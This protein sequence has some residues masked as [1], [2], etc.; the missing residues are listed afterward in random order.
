MNRPDRVTGRVCLERGSPV[1]VLTRWGPGGGLRNVLIQRKDGDLVV[2][3]FRGLRS[4]RAPR[5]GSMCTG[6]GGLDLAVASVLGGTLAWVADNDPAAARIL[7]HRFP[8]V[9]NHG[10]ITAVDW[11]TTEPVDVLTAGFPCQPVSAAGRRKGIS[12]ERWLW[13]D[14]VAAIGRM[15]SRPGLLVFENVPGLLSAN[16]GNAMARVVQGLA[17]LGY[18]GRYRLVRASSV[19]APHRR[20]RWFC[21]ACPAGDTF[22]GELQRRGIPAILRGQDTS[23]PAA[24]NE[25][26]HLLPTPAARDWKSGQ[27]NIMDRNSRPLNEVIETALPPTPRATDGTKGGP[28]QRG[29]SGDL[30]LPS[31]VMTLMAPGSA[32]HPG[33]K[34]GIY[35][36]AIRRWEHI[37]ARPAPH[38]TE[39]GR[40]GERLSPAFTE[41]MM[42]LP[43]GWVTGVPGLS[44]NAQLKAL[45]NGVV[46]QQAAMALRLLLG[47]DDQRNI[48]TVMRV[49]GCPQPG[50]STP[51][52]IPRQ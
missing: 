35:E 10:D 21:I 28:G 26:E 9:P 52:D 50:A 6:Y 18:V 51:V 49:P 27:S 29:S 5:I 42:G 36:A 11:G 8:H 12:D 37:F 23:L 14:I 30:M 4:V 47:E 16:S 17:K 34:W 40:N 41:W 1:T 24:A 48:R 25:I 43:G 32:V 20:E 19:G 13:D 22:G 45:G 46:P 7:A 33:T 44:R 2:R 39:P 15:G 38:P 3:P 31:A